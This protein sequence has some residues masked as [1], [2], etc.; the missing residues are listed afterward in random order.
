A[1]ES[2][3]NGSADSA[4]GAAENFAEDIE[5]IVEAAADSTALLKRGVTESIVS[6]AFVR[7]HQHV[8][9]FAQLLEFFLGVRVVRIFVRMKLDREFAISA[10]DFLCGRISP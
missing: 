3:E 4:A 7:I 5:R 1:E 2:F 9:G 8:V 10:F 6:G